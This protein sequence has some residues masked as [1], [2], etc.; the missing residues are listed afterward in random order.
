[1]LMSIMI[2]F[3]MSDIVILQNSVCTQKATRIHLSEVTV[4][5][6]HN[7]SNSLLCKR[8]CLHTTQEQSEILT[9]HEEVGTNQSLPDLTTFL[10]W[11]LIT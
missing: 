11:S 6:Y 9:L 3:K 10:T 5:R 2:Y 7:K 1:M 8:K 4:S